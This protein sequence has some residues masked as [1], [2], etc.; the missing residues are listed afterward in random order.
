ME[1]RNSGLIGGII[2]ILIGIGFLIVQF[3]PDVFA[4]WFQW[5]LLVIAVGFIFLV[6]AVLSREGGLAVPGAIVG[7][8]GLILYYQNTSGDWSSWSYI[9]TLIPGFVGIGILLAGL[10][11][12]DISDN[13]SGGLILVSASALGFIIFGGAFNL[14]WNVWR[15]WPVILIVVGLIAIVQAIVKSR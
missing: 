11:D 2:L 8:I 5:P 9:W 4:G 6:A 13:L 14:G 10:I 3:L 12:G 15:Y 1:N 7:G